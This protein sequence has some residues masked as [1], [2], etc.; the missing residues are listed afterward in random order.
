[1]TE[2]NEELERRYRATLDAFIVRARRVEEHSLAQDRAALVKLAQVTFNVEM[3]A[4]TGTTTFIQE[5]PPEEQVESA[6]A[7]IRPLILNDDPTYYAKAFKALSYLL[8]VAGAAEPVL[9][10]LKGL[11][12]DWAAIR[13]K[14]RDLSAYSIEASMAG[15]ADSELVTDNI[16]GFAWLYGDVVHSDAERLKETHTFGVVER[17]RAAVPLVAR[18]MM[19]TI[20][21]L[22][23]IRFLNQQGLVVIDAPIFDRQVVVTETT[24]RQEAKVYVGEYDAEGQPVSIPRGGEEP[25][26][27]WKPLH[28]AFGRSAEGL[29]PP[30]QAES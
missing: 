10:V 8:D 11:R 2:S 29:T 30:E 3:D 19:L 5:L 12:A 15:S 16:L 27:H 4:S 22:N 21:D 17:F 14:G 24:F 26:E 20:A 7:R 18:I 1:V 23:F 25:G 9:K 6:A 28:E 13:P